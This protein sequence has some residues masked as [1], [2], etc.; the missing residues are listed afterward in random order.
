MAECVACTQ[1]EIVSND[2]IYGYWGG[3]LSS[4]AGGNGPMPGTLLLG[5]SFPI[6]DN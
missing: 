5:W 2:L 6:A 3:V 1:F 4:V